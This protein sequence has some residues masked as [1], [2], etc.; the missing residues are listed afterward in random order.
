MDSKEAKEI[1][2]RSTTVA[3]GYDPATVEE[4]KDLYNNAIEIASVAQQA[5]KDGLQGKALLNAKKLICGDEW[6]AKRLTKSREKSW[7]IFLQAIDSVEADGKPKRNVKY[8]L[9]FAGYKEAE[10]NLI[11]E[12]IEVETI[13]TASHYREVKKLTAPLPPIYR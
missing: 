2:R 12:G 6:N 10:Q 3:M 1:A 5:I 11:D 8:L 4:C 9:D 7:N 13:D